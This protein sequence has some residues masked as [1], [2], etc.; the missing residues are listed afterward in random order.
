MTGGGD[1]WFAEDGVRHFW[2]DESD[3]GYSITM[4]TD[5]TA[6]LNDAQAQR[7]HNDGWSRSRELRRAAHIPNAI[8]L[9]WK[10]EGFDMYDR[11]NKAELLRRLDSSD[12]SHFRT[13]DGRLGR[14]A[15]R[16]I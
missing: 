15:G 16:M 5:V 4:S 11:N 9:K 13:A 3:G 7:T 6:A 2:R 14:G 1:F 8:I 12:Y 10:D